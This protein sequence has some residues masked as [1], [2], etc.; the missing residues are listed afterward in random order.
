MADIFCPICREPWDHDELHESPNFGTERARK[1]WKTVYNK[2]LDKALEDMHK[3]G[4]D[5]GKFVDGRARYYANGWTFRKY[6]CEL[7][8]CTHDEKEQ[9]DAELQAFYASTPYPEEW[10]L[11]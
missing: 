6:G 2:A 9:P 5:N 4:I 1:Y 8:G 3:E 7:F 11:D 10:I